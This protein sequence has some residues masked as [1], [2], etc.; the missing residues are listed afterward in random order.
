MPACRSANATQAIRIVNQ[1]LQALPQ[2]IDVSGWHEEGSLAIG[3][4]ILGALQSRAKRR[5]TLPRG[6]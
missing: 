2:R 6:L 4:H 3:Q 1:R 5:D